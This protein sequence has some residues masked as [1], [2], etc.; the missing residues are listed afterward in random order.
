MSFWGL[1][2]WAGL[3]LVGLLY[4]TLLV[5]KDPLATHYPPLKPI[6][7]EACHQLGCRI[8][9]LRIP[10]AVV[11]DFAS[12]DLKQAAQAQDEILLGLDEP[13]WTV[14]IHLRNADKVPVATPWLELTLTNVQDAALVRKVLNPVDWGG[15]DVISLG[16][17]VEYELVMKL[18]KQ[19]SAF[20]GY[21]LLTFY[22]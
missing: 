4:Q 18:K 17:I 16:E 3:G 8:H 15:A 6:L 20:M 12:I 14:Q 10:D 7:I 2:T 13:Q 11:I 9:P 21:R 22:P 5:F 1:V 19:H